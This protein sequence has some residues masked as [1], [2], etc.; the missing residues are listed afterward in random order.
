MAIEKRTKDWMLLAASNLCRA[1]M[2]DD[3][4]VAR[5]ALQNVKDTIDSFLWEAIKNDESMKEVISFNAAPI[6]N[7]TTVK[8]SKGRQQANGD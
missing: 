6:K 7:Q 4:K 1:V 5:I 3:T 2:I 8:E